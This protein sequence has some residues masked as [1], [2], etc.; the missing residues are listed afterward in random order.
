MSWRKKCILLVDD[1][2]NFRKG[3][4]RTLHRQRQEWYMNSAQR[5]DAALDLIAKAA[6]DTI[7]ERYAETMTNE[8]REGMSSGQ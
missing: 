2:P 5:V 1:E 4:K 7:H 8:K 3:I 6:F